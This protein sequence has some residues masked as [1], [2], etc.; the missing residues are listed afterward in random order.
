MA[1]VCPA[2]PGG[3]SPCGPAGCVAG[4]A[5]RPGRRR[6]CRV[7]FEGG[8]PTC[9]RASSSQRRLCMPGKPM[10]WRV[11]GVLVARGIEPALILVPEL[12]VVGDD[13][14]ELARISSAASTRRAA[15]NGSSGP[16]S[17]ACA[18]QSAPLRGCLHGPRLAGQ[19]VVLPRA[20][21]LVDAG[22]GR[23]PVTS[24]GLLRDA[25][26]WLC[27]GVRPRDDHT[28]PGRRS[29]MRAFDHRRVAADRSAR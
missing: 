9:G 11:F 8:A 6:A 22:T 1:R 12:D 5:A 21:P 15:T 28:F 20:S 25:M 2:G 24:A 10:P 17:R 18:G 29:P 3:A 4:C 13:V 19:L 27:N 7:I 16:S 23:Q 26:A 14:L